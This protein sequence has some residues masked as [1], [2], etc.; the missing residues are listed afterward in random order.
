MIV[1][2]T[3]ASGIEARFVRARRDS[4]TGRRFVCSVVV[5]GVSREVRGRIGVVAGR[6]AEKRWVGFTE[7]RM[8][9][10]AWAAVGGDGDCWSMDGVV[11]RNWRRSFTAPCWASRPRCFCSLA[12]EW[13]ML[14]LMVRIVAVWPFELLRRTGT[15]PA[16]STFLHRAVTHLLSSRGLSSTGFCELAY[17]FS[18]VMR[19]CSSVRVGR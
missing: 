3:V 15:S 2:E 17:D 11:E 18:C 16:S 5:S 12:R 6:A 13:M 7:I 14:T 19:F 4:K 8:R 9:A 10:R 1:S